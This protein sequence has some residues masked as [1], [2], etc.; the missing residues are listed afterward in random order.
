MASVSTAPD[1]VMSIRRKSLAVG[2]GKGGV[3]KS[4]TAL[5]IALLLSRLTY[6]VA[7]LDL[8]PLSNVS[9][10]LDIPLSELRN[11]RSDPRSAGTLAHFR[12]PY[13]PTLDIVFPHAT[14]R[15]L[16]AE[17]KHQLF[18]RFL[19]DL[20]RSYD[21][22]ILDMPAGIS[23]EEN[24]KFLP[25]VG[26]LL[27]VTNAEPTSHVSA[28]G[29]LRSVFEIRPHMSVRVWHNRYQP[30]G[31]TG[32]DP[33]AVVENYNKY[34]D[35]ELRIRERESALMDDIAFVPP[36]PSLNLLQTDLDPSFTVYSKLRE[37][38][39]LIQD[40]LLRTVFSTAELTRRT[41]DLVTYYVSH[42]PRIT[43]VDA[44]LSE[45][46]RFLEGLIEEEMRDKLAQI[47]AK[48]GRDG[49]FRVLSAGQAASLRESLT[50]L[51]NDELFLELVRVTSVLSGALEAA[52]NA[53]R[54]FL[55]RSSLDHGKIVRSAMP[56]LL[57]LVAR[58]FRD[59]AGRLSV[60][61]RHS[62]ATALFLVAADK[63]FDDQQTRTMLQRLVPRRKKR[64]GSL[65][66]DR[67]RQILRVLARDEE[68]HRLFFQVIKAVFPGITRRMSALNKSYA[69]SPLFLR[70]GNGEINA[71]AYVK[72]TTHL[73]H[74]LVNAGLGVSISATYNAASQAIR[75]GVEKLIDD[76]GW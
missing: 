44:H 27:L 3:G 45:I 66:R 14:T 76:R 23:A 42:K 58:E 5:N 18:V 39:D 65:H 33:R 64:D 54:G 67:Y 31:E 72:L 48:L 49:G 68:Y 40:D 37:V 59:G 20:D 22:L 38:L 28:G 8:D 46:D 55:E 47:H 12:Y 35:E 6:R 60:F 62:A 10:I 9:T 43:D 30:A 4:T 7:L 69:L 41:R 26:S 32:F 17:Q 34:A 51:A 11:V 75:S 57:S 52:A 61:S 53:G 70:N 13:A 19:D 50:T 15:D 24:L 2:S 29:Y 36:D 56:R 63:E 73:L 21:V 25:W 1:Q 74:D 16:A 71:Q